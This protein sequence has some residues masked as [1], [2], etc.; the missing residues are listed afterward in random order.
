MKENKHNIRDG[1]KENKKIPT[2]KNARQPRSIEPK[3]KKEKHHDRLP[4]LGHG[5]VTERNGAHL[6]CITCT[7]GLY[8]SVNKICSF[9]YM[10]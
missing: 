7:V 2:N 6:G 1:A 8:Y 9:D 10:K 4:R 3:E 5:L